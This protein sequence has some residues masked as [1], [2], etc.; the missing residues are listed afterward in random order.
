MWAV[1]PTTAYVEVLPENIE[2]LY[3]ERKER[4]MLEQQARSYRW[5]A[6]ELS[7]ALDR[8][9]IKLYAQLH[10][11]LLRHETTTAVF[12]KAKYALR[13]STLL[14]HGLMPE[15]LFPIPPVKEMQYKTTLPYALYPYQRDSVSSLIKCRHGFVEMATGCGKS[16][17]LLELIRQTSL[18]A[19]IV[20]PGKEN[21]ASLFSL[22]STHFGADQVGVYGDG[23][24]QITK[25]ITVCIAK[26]LQLIDKKK[27]PEVFH[28]FQRK[29]LLIVDESHTWATAALALLCHHLFAFVPYRC[30]LSATQ[31]KNDDEDP[32]LHSIIGKRAYTLT[33]K[34]A[35]QHNYIDDH[36]FLILKTFPASNESNRREGQ[37]D[38]GTEITEKIDPMHVRRID[39]LLNQNIAESI[40]KMLVDFEYRQPHR[41]V[42]I[43]VDQ[44]EQMGLL[45]KSMD[46]HNVSQAFRRNILYIHNET[47]KDRLLT[48]GLLEEKDGGEKMKKRMSVTEQVAAFNRGEKS[49][50]IATSCVQT[51]A[52]FYTPHFCINWV[53]G[54]MSNCI[55]TC[56]GSV[57]RS[58]RK[59]Q[60][61]PFLHEALQNK[62]VP[63]A[64][65]IIIDFDVNHAQLKKHL[66]KRLDYY[67]LSGTAIQWLDR[68][69]DMSI[70]DRLLEIDSSR[71]NGDENNERQCR[72]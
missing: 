20:V 63:K 18:D 57:G 39:F 13:T 5:S 44:V 16:V 37:T 12:A 40:V 67:A 52:S 42:M 19:V 59:W 32:L 47:N 56:Q 49:V 50:M 36:S 9:K 68:Q 35:L 60:A 48:L 62:L 71:G 41:A 27:D 45:V 65:T 22:C 58:V 3:I 46:A 54:G 72:A 1:T 64:K 23:K 33:T 70:D 25:R 66:K 26:S 28:H 15:I 14:Y 10:E 11:S 55:R 2:L 21:C 53:G 31:V 34:E 69:S 6:K 17:I 43:L 4:K 24:K 7:I 38:N 8:K 61:N 30:F 51:G 29:Q